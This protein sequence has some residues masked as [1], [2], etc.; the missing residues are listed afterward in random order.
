MQLV[1]EDC[2]LHTYE[3]LEQMDFEIPRDEL[4]EE[5]YVPAWHRLG[6]VYFTRKNYEDA[7]RVYEELLAWAEENDTEL[8]VEVYYVSASAFYYL[9]HTTDDDEPLC[10]LAVP[11]AFTALDIY[12]DKRLEDPN[13]LNNILSVLV[14]CRDYAFTPPT[15]P[16]NFPANYEEPDVRLEL[17]GQ[18]GEGGEDAA[19]GEDESGS[20]SGDVQPGDE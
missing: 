10:N 1:C 20:R 5:V 19:G 4:P 8:P 16:V 2:P 9:A 6:M 18:G 15:I 13:A 7:I 12:E 17:P 14:L 11:R 3:E